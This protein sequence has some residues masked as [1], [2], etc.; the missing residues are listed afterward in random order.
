M[1]RIQIEVVRGLVQQQRFRLSK[2]GLR[3]QYAHLLPALQFAHLAFVQ[4]LSDVQ[5]VEQHGGIG[6]GRV[7]ILV[8]DYAF[9]FAQPHAVG[10]AQFGLLVN[11]VSLFEGRPERLI[12]HDD[13]IDHAIAVECELILAQY[14]QLPRTHYRALLRVQFAGQD[15]HESGF[16]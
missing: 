16:A 11:A 5:T 3:Q 10:I 9:Q 1:H 8:A 6:L 2:Q 4:L 7:A 14:A 12:A 15:F 13:R